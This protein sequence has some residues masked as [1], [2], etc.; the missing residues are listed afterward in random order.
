M[1]DLTQAERYL[2]EQIRQGSSD[3]WQQLVD[4]YQGRLLAFARSRAVNRT[5]AEDLVQ[6]TFL[7]F[8][9]SLPTFREEASLETWLFMILRRRIVDLL[10]GK[11][12]TVCTLQDGRPD[13]DSSGSGSSMQFAAPDPTASTYARRDERLD[14][15]RAALTQALAELVNALKESQDFR[16]LKI[17]EMLFFGQLRNKDIAPLV[18]LDEKNIALIKHRW[19]KQL[20]Q[21]VADR[22]KNVD[23]SAIETDGAA[24]SLLTEIWEE[25]RLSCPKRSTLGGYLL[26]TLDPPWHDYVD[27][28]INQLGCRFCRANLEDLKSQSAAAPRVLVDRIMQSTVGFFRK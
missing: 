15:E 2:T 9:K 7:Q 13:D 21:R 4:R 10:R 20:R 1:N 24:D 12:V 8:L 22:L 11:R 27:F 23:L 16:D 18:Q 17:I 5:D 25:Q 14:H 6:E 28:H 26:N 3:A 19:L